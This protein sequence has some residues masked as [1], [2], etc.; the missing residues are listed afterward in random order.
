MRP[1]PPFKDGPV[2]PA[3][4]PLAITTEPKTASD[5]LPTPEAAAAAS[6]IV[7]VEI[8]SHLVVRVPCD[9]PVDRVASLVR[10]MRGTA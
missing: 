5:A 3:F 8:G 7:T 10:T 2:E 1:V 9:M 6:G 4:V